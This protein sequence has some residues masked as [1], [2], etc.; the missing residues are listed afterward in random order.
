MDDFDFDLSRS[1]KIKYD[2]AIELPIYDFL[3]IVRVIYS[4]T[5]LL[6]EI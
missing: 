6:Y 5:R 2:G 1:L 3:L 4:I